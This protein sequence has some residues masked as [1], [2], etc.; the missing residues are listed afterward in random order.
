MAS[1]QPLWPQNGLD[2][3][4]MIKKSESAVLITHIS[5]PLIYYS[6]CTK[7]KSSSKPISFLLV[8]ILGSINDL[9]GQKTASED[10]TDL[11]T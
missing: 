1:K 9:G 8:F 4:K 7:P 3:K 10:K 5:M 6:R 2:V 11:R